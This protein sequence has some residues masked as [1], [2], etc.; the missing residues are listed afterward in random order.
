M[1]PVQTRQRNVLTVAKRKTVVA[2]SCPP[3]TFRGT[4]NVL[5]VDSPS[6][7]TGHS[8]CVVPKGAP[9][10]EPFAG[11]SSEEPERF[12]RVPKES[13]RQHAKDCN[14]EKS[15][16]SH[17]S[18]SSHGR[19]RSK[20]RPEKSPRRR[21]RRR[22]DH[23]KSSASHDAIVL[24]QDRQTPNPARQSRRTRSPSAQQDQV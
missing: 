24:A 3:G 20:R 16:A 22:E 18:K 13:T 17:S 11:R 19:G 10:I 14:D 12:T 15:N 6:S 2:G 4:P 23:H 21:T 1:P 7:S 9:P 5:R 8:P